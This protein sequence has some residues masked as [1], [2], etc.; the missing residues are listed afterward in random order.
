PNNTP[1][2]LPHHSFTQKNNPCGYPPTIPP[3]TN[4]PIEANWGFVGCLNNVSNNG[5]TCADTVL[6]YAPL[7]VGPGSPNT[8]YYG[9]DHLY[10]SAD[11]G[12]TNT[13]VSQVFVPGVAVS[14]IGISPQ[15]DTVRLV[16]LENGQVFATTAGANP[17]TNVTGPW[18]T[19]PT[20]PVY[21]ARAVIDPN[22]KTT[23]Y[24]TLDGY[25]TSNH[26]WKTTNLL[27][28]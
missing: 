20:N 21:V 6:F 19:G 1:V 15:D 22:N 10:R 5:I 4:P 13:A 9:T 23:A 17:M 28:E 14:A 3:A 2:P 11:N 12:N 27:G 25:T 16:G 24:I 8:V 7:T 18:T 26:V